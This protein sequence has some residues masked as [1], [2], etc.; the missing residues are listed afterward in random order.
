MTALPPDPD[1]A[2]TPGLEPG[3]GVN[4]GDTPPDS[5]STTE[6]LSHHERK[7]P[8]ATAGRI[9]IAIIVLFAVLVAAM[10]LTRAFLLA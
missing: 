10:L 2:R 7:P 4:P 5:G 8:T 1:P 9:V 6:G 3:G